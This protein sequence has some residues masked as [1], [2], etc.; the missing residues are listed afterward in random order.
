MTA[1]GAATFDAVIWGIMPGGNWGPIGRGANAGHVNEGTA[2]SFTTA[3]Q[4]QDIKDN[5]GS[6]ER[7]YLRIQNST[8]SP[9][10]NAW[11][12]FIEERL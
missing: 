7:L 1:A 6:F 3:A 2:L 5:L 10:I 9:T 11:L 8:G 12:Q 4:W